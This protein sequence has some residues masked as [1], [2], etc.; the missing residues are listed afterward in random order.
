MAGA[1]A[2]TA[3]GVPGCWHRDWSALRGCN[4]CC[5][6]AD[7][8]SNTAQ[9]EGRACIAKKEEFKGKK[10]IAKAQSERQAPAR[11]PKRPRP[12]SQCGKPDEHRS[13]AGPPKSLDISHG[14]GQALPFKRTGFSKATILSSTAPIGVMGPL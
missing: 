1:I 7:S 6:E 10:T 8:K 9:G 14:S 5:K 2:G 4:W 13:H 12:K 3:L 11:L